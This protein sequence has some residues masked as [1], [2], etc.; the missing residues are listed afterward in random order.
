MPRGVR[1]GPAVEVEVVRRLALRPEHRDGAAPPVAARTPAREVMQAR[2]AGEVRRRYAA[3]ACHVLQIS[4]QLRPEAR[5]EVQGLP[6]GLDVEIDKA[7][8]DRDERAIQRR[9]I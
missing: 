8:L 9:Q 2:E 3:L 6:D 5:L 4:R 7:V 1:A